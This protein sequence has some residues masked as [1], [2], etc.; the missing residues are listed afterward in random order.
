MSIPNSLKR[1]IAAVV[2]ASIAI[3]N[4]AIP[5][6]ANEAGRSVD[7]WKTDLNVDLRPDLERPEAPEEPTIP[8]DQ[9]VR[10]SIVLDE[11]ST[12]DAGYEIST[13]SVD[14]LAIA[15]RDDLKVKQETL[16]TKIER[17]ALDGKELDVVWNLTLAANLISANVEYGQIDDIKAVPGVKDVV[18]EMQYEPAEVTAA[19]KPNMGTSSGMIGS[20]VAY[21]G[22]Y[23]GAGSKVAIIDTGIDSD[24]QSFDAGAFEYSLDKLGYEG[25][26][27]EK[28]DL[29]EEL[30]EQLNIY[31]YGG[32]DAGRLYV[33]S[34]IPFA[35]N[36]VDHG[37]DITHDNDT[38]G[39]HGSHVTGISAANAYIPN[40]SGY[41]PALTSVLTQ[42]VAPDAQI[43][44]MKVFGKGGGAYDSDYMAAIED[45]IVLGADS[46]N[47]SLGSSVAGM[48]HSD[49]YGD[50][51][52]SLTENGAVVTISAGNNGYWAENSKSVGIFDDPDFGPSPDYAG[53]LYGDDVNFTTAGSPGTYTNALTIASVDNDGFTGE[54][55][56]VGGDIIFYTQS[57]GYKNPPYSI[58][59]GK[60]FKYVVMDSIGTVE[61]FESVADLIDGN[62]AVCYRGEISF[63]EKADAAWANGAAGVI[64]INNQPGTIN[65]DLSDYTGDVP[66]VSITY[67]DGEILWDAATASGTSDNGVDYAVGELK[68][69]SDIESTA[70]N[71]DYYTMSSFSSWGVPGT[72]EMK[73]EITAPGGNIYS[74]NGLPKE[75]DQYENMSG[76]SM[77][78]PQVAGMAAVLAQYIRESEELSALIED[79][80][81]TQRQLIQSLLM[82][83]AVPVVEEATGNYYS[84]LNQGAGLANVGAATQAH[85][86]IL[87][88][89]DAT[90][91]PV[92]AQDGKVKVELGETGDKFSYKFTVNNFSDEAML[93]TLDTDLFTQDLFWDDYHYE[94]FLDTWT[95]PIAADVTYLLDGEPIEA[96]SADVNMDG[97]TN[98]DDAQALLE[99]ITSGDD[100]GL[101]L[102][103][104]DIDGDEKYTTYDAYLILVGM[105]PVAV[106]ANS[107]VEVTVQ[108]TLN[109]PALANYKNGAY[110]EGYTFLNPSSNSEGA[111]DV[112]YSI[113]ILGFYGNWSDPSMYDT[114]NVIDS[115]LGYETSRHDYPYVGGYNILFYEDGESGVEYF[116]TGNPYVDPPYVVE[117][118]Y[119][120]EL[121]SIRSIDI[122][123]EYDFA[124]IRNAGTLAAVITDANT[125]EVIAVKVDSTD[126]Y[127][128]YYNASNNTWGN[129]A[130]YVDFGIRVGDLPGVKEGDAIN[131]SVVAIP[132]YYGTHLDANGVKAV[133]SKLGDGAFLTT[134]LNIDDTAP[135]IEE[136]IKGDDGSVT[137]KVSDNVA[138]A[139]VA[140]LSKSGVMMY[141]DCIPESDTV[142][143]SAEEINENGG[144]NT[145]YAVVYAGDYAANYTTAEFKYGE[146]L[147][148]VGELFGVGGAGFGYS[149][150]HKLHPDKLGEY[151]EGGYDVIDLTP[152]DVYAA[153]YADG[154]IFQAGFDDVLYVAPIQYPGDFFAEVIPLDSIEVSNTLDVKIFDMTF[155]YADSQIY[156]LDCDGGIWKI[157]PLTGK[158]EFQYKLTAEEKFVI[159]GLTVDYDGNFYT[160]AGYGDWVEDK[161]TGDYEFDFTGYLYTW[162]EEDAEDGIVKLTEKFAVDTYGRLAYDLDNDKI[163]MAAT[164]QENWNDYLYEIDPATGEYAPTTDTYNEELDYEAGN[165][166]M[167]YQ[168][169]FAVPSEDPDV[170]D[171]TPTDEVGEFYVTPEELNLMVG[172]TANLT[173]FISPWTLSDRSVTWSSADTTVA[174][175]DANGKVTAVGEGET[176]ITAAANVDPDKTAAVAVTVVPMPSVPLSGL[177]FDTDSRAYW[178][179]F[180]LDDPASFKHVSDAQSNFYSGTLGMD[181]ELGD[182]YLYAMDNTTLYAIDP[183]D[184]FAAYDV[185]TIGVHFDYFSDAAPA[186]LFSYLLG[187]DMIVSTAY[188]GTEIQMYLTY[189]QS[190]LWW[191]SDE[192]DFGFSIPMAAIAYAGYNIDFDSKYPFEEYY[193]VILENGDVYM[194]LFA[195]SQE[196]RM[197]FGNAYVGSTGIDLSSVASV[198][199]SHSA[200]LHYDFANDYL[201]LAHYDDNGDT[202]YLSLIGFD[203]NYDVELLATTDFGS[204]VWPVVALY[205]DEADYEAAD[206]A[207]NETVIAAFDGVQTQGAAEITT[208][209][210]K[211]GIAVVEEETADEEVVD[212]D[213]ADEEIVDEEEPGD[214]ENETEDVSAV[215]VL[216]VGS[217]NAVNDEVVDVVDGE[218]SD[219]DLEVLEKLSNALVIGEPVVNKSKNTI[220]IPVEATRATNALYELSYDSSLLT[221]DSVNTLTL[222]ASYEEDTESVLLNFASAN[223]ET[224]SVSCLVFTYDEEDEDGLKTEITLSAYEVGV[225]PVKGN[226]VLVALGDKENPVAKEISKEIEITED[227]VS[228]APDPTPNPNPN[229]APSGPSSPA[230]PSE[231]N[232]VNIDINL[233]GNGSTNAPSTV[234]PGKDLEFTITP[235]DGYALPNSITITIGGRVLDPSEYSYDPITGK[236]IIPGSKITG[237]ISVDVNFVPISS[238][239]GQPSNGSDAK[240]GVSTPDVTPDNGNGNG[241]GNGSYNG[242]VDQNPG[243]GVTVIFVPALVSAAAIM[244]TKRRKSK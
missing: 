169:L 99:Y 23:T 198:D 16:E 79:G 201:Y 132:E 148:Y 168:S 205:Q 211:N 223:P 67:A 225:A 129:A 167:S 51:M 87:M 162:T 188:G 149:Q 29:T 120:Y 142:F 215:P 36:Y 196:G 113:P 106:P 226:G 181:Y 140:L 3:A 7:F 18:I 141:A 96:F 170:I 152:V 134:R 207:A 156:V 192:Y 98:N 53:Y 84:I 76:T 202:A 38:Q 178:S 109:D 126:E 185:G 157:N 164:N 81:V 176:T 31:A 220:T 34:K 115:V 102:A 224:K 73:P 125:G 136:I 200:S 231:S 195:L 229:P 177:V 221:L 75:T 186:A 88:D 209:A 90:L 44:T 183:T 1:T 151:G 104:G 222:Y 33:S 175:V 58:Y 52:D 244:V 78:A 21:Q 217:L 11:E 6:S 46:I 237:N 234:K 189:S 59:A 37:Y 13:L 124:L 213:A 216:P 219:D 230:E 218:L 144:I 110:I 2:A 94:Q 89:E 91:D 48:G 92:S 165:L 56:Q 72:L 83:T 119:P 171:D 139:Y 42:G 69:G 85:S 10:V 227:P 55:L 191:D 20:G 146:P 159:T 238:Q 131:V 193:Y 206:I 49:L 123:T 26:L 199:G 114:F 212:E 86:Y 4:V 22:G 61:D 40:G 208:L 77:A 8:D 138:V 57:S 214:D 239:G 9:V 210:E 242:N 111:V 108:V 93:Y 60:T 137:V 24:H 62:I 39:E 50:V 80:V 173:Y 70:Y 35:Y 145:E 130:D 197:A 166:P 172:A 180:T 161:E 54:F 160:T 233:G 19:D 25:D 174:V 121:A 45:A 14:P 190:G 68:V 64:V 41:T 204:D 116:Q 103:A 143:F 228:P 122:L 117:E 241:N 163:Y 71:S 179:K 187:D 182:T 194:F 158:T 153:A 100:T 27:L 155:N 47:L 128:A 15:Y 236:V 154:Y 203:E 30:L 5:V 43:I 74:V 63:S 127:A 112:T 97:V 28:S 133:L 243:T 232:D 150:W 240:P 66:V 184:G 105:Y 101:D 107:S 235:A 118:D 95:T 147:K 32:I 135:T 17:Q 12:I 65:M 82:S